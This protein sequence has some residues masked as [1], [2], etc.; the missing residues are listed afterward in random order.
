MDS[1]LERRADFAMLDADEGSG[2]LGGA[3]AGFGMAAIVTILFNTVLA[4][5]KDAFDPLNTFMAHLTGHHWITHGLANVA[6]FLIVGVVLTARGYRVSGNALA[7]GVV[8]AAIVGGGG[9]AVW[10]LLV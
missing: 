2:M 7:F 8:L 4:W 3:A 9:L 1:T 6:L 10:F 5:V